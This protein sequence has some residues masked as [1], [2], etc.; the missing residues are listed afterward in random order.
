MNSVTA[1]LNSNIRVSPDSLSPQGQAESIAAWRDETLAGTNPAWPLPLPPWVVNVDVSIFDPDG[2]DEI[3]VTLRGRD[4]TAG[5][6][7]SNVE[8]T[9]L[10]HGAIERSTE[11]VFTAYEEPVVLV[12]EIQPIQTSAQALQLAEVIGAAGA[13]LRDIEAAGR[14]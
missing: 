2:D 12:P 13:E 3:I 8:V 4:W 9:Y 10:V 1:T 5:Q 7:H 11:G 6:F 14:G